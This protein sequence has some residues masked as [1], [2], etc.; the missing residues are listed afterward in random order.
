VHRNR[1]EI[2]QE[3]GVVELVPS[4]V[5]VRFLVCKMESSGTETSRHIA[6]R[7]GLILN[8][9]FLQNLSL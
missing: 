7:R 3:V 4:V 6:D 5:I 9:P 2:E 1:F 8:V